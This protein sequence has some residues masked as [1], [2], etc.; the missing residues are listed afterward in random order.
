MT[1]WPE[2]GL[3]YFLDIQKKIAILGVKA[4]NQFKLKYPSLNNSPS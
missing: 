2:R 4:Y 1:F 3:G